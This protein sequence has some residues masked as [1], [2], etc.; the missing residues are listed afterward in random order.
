MTHR[1][2][3]RR[4]ALQGG[5][6]L[7]GALAFGRLP[8]L[9]SAAP[10]EPA[11]VVLW[12]NGGPAGLFNSAGSFL[13]NGAFGVT[14]ANVRDLGGDLLVDAGSLGSLPEPARTH[15]ASVNFRH[16]VI[17]PHEQA[18]AAVLE[19]SGRSRLLRMAAAFP[20]AEWRC[21]VVIDLGF[22]AGVRA[23][24]PADDGI[25]LERLMETEPIAQR[26]G[27]SRWAQIRSAYGAPERSTISDSASTFAAI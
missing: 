27:A 10:E 4:Q 19:E 17:R 14:P 15:M 11:L 20:A 5:A 24:P 9:R 6:A 23:E 2:F 3:T 1:T 26:V 22:P 25:A 21:A 13:R 12:L 16:G 7:T 18:R 8:G